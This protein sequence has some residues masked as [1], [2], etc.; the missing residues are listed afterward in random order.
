MPL[1]LKKAFLFRSFINFD[2]DMKRVIINF[3][4]LWILLIGGSQL[5]HAYILPKN[6]VESPSWDFVKKHQI[7]YKTLDSNSVLIE[8]ADVDLDEEFHSGDNLNDGNTNNFAVSNHKLLDNWYFTF[9][10]DFIFKD[11]TKQIKISTT[12]CGYTNPIYLTIGVFRI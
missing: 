5:I 10:N 4:Y 12:P 7:K 3:M 1:F 8:E 11:N 9:I 6:L 2:V